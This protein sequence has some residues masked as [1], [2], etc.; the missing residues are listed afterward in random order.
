[1][2]SYIGLLRGINVGG[3]NMLKMTDIRDCLRRNG[4]RN[5]Q[6][7]IQS[8]NLIFEAPEQ[9]TELQARTIEALIAKDFGLAVPTVVVTATRWKQIVEHAPA[10]WGVDATWKHN[11]LVLIEPYNIQE[12]MESVGTIKPDIESLT[13]GQGV[14][15]QSMS[16]ELFG[17]TTTGKLASSPLYKKMTVRNYNTCMKLIA[18]CAETNV[19]K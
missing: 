4:Y 8:G 17:K 13:A 14:L 12:V 15:Y 16:K 11:L 18:M 10:T 9:D 3:K 2:I 1:M 6:S 7:Y 5:V 19:A